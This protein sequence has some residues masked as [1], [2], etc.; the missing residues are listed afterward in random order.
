MHL[1]KK[2]KTFHLNLWLNLEENQQFFWPFPDPFKDSMQGA[3]MKCAY[4]LWF[5][6]VA[7]RI[8][9]AKIFN[10]WSF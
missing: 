3:N 5:Q 7:F 8:L 1:Q 2:E 10:F 9:S 4:S 6:E